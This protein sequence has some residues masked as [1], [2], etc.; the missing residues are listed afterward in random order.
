M[1]QLELP[2]ILLHANDDP[3][4]FAAGSKQLFELSATKPE[5]K[6]LMLFAAPSQHDLLNEEG[7]EGVKGVICSWIEHV[8]AGGQGNGMADGRSINGSL[9]PLPWATRPTNE[10]VVAPDL[11][12][13]SV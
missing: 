2:F 11:P 13:K 1:A 7:H 3:F 6:H 12:I 9:A 5:E 4:S 8:T 10:L